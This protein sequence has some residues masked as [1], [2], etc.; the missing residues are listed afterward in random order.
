MKQAMISLQRMA[1]E[2][3]LKGP[4]HERF[5]AGLRNIKTRFGSVT[6]LQIILEKD[7]FD[8]RLECAAPKR[9]SKYT[10]L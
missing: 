10:T 7:N 9:W 8:Q 1:Y 6:Y 4:L 5:E 3:L 2:S